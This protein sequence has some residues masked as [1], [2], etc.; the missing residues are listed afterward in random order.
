M[1]R[2]LLAKLFLLELQ[3]YMG[4]RA[5][6]LKVQNVKEI[7]EIILPKK[8]V[9]KDKMQELIKQKH[10]ARFL[11]RESYHRRNRLQREI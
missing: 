10:K 5:P 2:T 6:R 7:L 3:I 8:K 11:P 9:T 4:K 1:V